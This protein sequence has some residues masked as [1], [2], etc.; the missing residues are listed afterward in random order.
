M[1]SRVRR[2][3]CQGL[4]LFPSLV[5]CRAD[6]D[7]ANGDRYFRPAEDLSPVR[8]FHA[9]ATDHFQFRQGQ[10][11]GPGGVG[12]AIDQAEYREGR[13]AVLS[14]DNVACRDQFVRL[15]HGAEAIAFVGNELPREIAAERLGRTLV[16][17]GRGS[18][19]RGTEDGL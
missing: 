19:G 3:R 16:A 11:E 9:V 8:I 5:G 17:W 12:L 14:Q 6:L 1:V 18:S 10:V 13:L 7:H 4:Q 15:R 2:V